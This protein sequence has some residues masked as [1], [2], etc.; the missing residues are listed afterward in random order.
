ML[1]RSHRFP[2]TTRTHLPPMIHLAQIAG[3]PSHRG[4]VI[5]LIAGKTSMPPIQ[6]R[7]TSGTVTEPSAFW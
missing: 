4:G 1:H 3:E 6:G 2:E 5:Q 7:S